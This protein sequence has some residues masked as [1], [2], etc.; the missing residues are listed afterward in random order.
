MNGFLGADTESLR[1]AGGTV[2]RGAQR[3]DDLAVRLAA[4]IE[5]VDWQGPDAEAFRVDWAARVRPDLDRSAMRLREDSRELTDHAE[6]QDA[7]SDPGGESGRG[8]GVGE[9]IGAV[10][11]ALGGA[12]GAAIGAAATAAEAATEMELGE[13][14]LLAASAPLDG[15]QRM[16]ASAADASDAVGAESEL[17]YDDTGMMLEPPP[18]EHTVRVDGDHELAPS[19]DDVPFGMDSEGNP[20][21]L[22]PETRYDVGDHGTYYTDGNG[23]VVYVEATGGGKQMNPNLREVFPDATYHVNESTYYQTDELG[24]TEHMY[25]PDV[26]VDRDMSRSQSIQSKIAERWDMAGDGTSEPVEF[27]AGHVLARQLGGIREEINYTRQWDEVNQSRSGKDTIY[28]Y[29][30]LMADGIEDDGKSYSYE[31]R[32]NWGDEQPKGVSPEKG[33]APWE[34][35]P[36]SYDVT[37]HEDGEKIVDDHLANYP[38][39]AR[40]PR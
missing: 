15:A 39:G 19:A 22:D 11:R 40:F 7:T 1:Q 23:D 37:I 14:Q 10:G 4:L 25:V 34:Y 20:L 21:Q 12:A 6:E 38:D 32:V 35:V 36:E 17:A 16:A 31:T 26:I 28:T 18:T 2:E 30:T 27:N 33:S 9:A 13:I 29:E 24:R 8:A 3:I 5:S